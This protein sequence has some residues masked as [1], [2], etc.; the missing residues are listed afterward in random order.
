MEV[1][2]KGKLLLTKKETIDS[3]SAGAISLE[4]IQRYGKNCI[5][6]KIT[7]SDSQ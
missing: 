1:V 7:G 5:R 2:Y 3:V 4:M 6:V